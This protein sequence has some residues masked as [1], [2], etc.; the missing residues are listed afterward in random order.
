MASNFESLAIHLQVNAFDNSERKIEALEGLRRYM[1][2][3]ACD[4]EHD[5]IFPHA[6]LD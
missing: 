5:L 2:Q 6:L 4:S 1:Y 3:T